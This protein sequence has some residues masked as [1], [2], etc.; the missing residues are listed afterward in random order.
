MVYSTHMVLVVENR[1]LKGVWWKYG[2]TLACLQMLAWIATGFLLVPNYSLSFALTQGVP[3]YGTLAALAFMPFV[4]VRLGLRRTY[5]C[6][7]VG[8]FLGEAVFYA[9]VA[10]GPTRQLG[11]GLLPFIAFCQVAAAL[12]S[13]GIVLDFGAYVYKKVF[14]E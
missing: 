13:F 8:F 3:V 7:L 14:E 11:G 10:Y 2:L 1:K 12:T 6:A 5:W 9:L 4:W